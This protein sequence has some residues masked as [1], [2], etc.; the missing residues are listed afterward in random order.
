LIIMTPHIVK[1][2]EDAEEIRQ[3]EASRMNWCL[4]DVIEMHG[5]GGLRGR[6]DEWSDAETNVIYPDLDPSGQ[7]SPTPNDAPDQPNIVPAPDNPPLQ[8]PPGSPDSGA[9]MPG[10]PSIEAASVGRAVYPTPTYPGRIEPAIYQGAPPPALL[11]QRRPGPVV[12]STYDAPLRPLHSP[13]LRLPP[14]ENR[15]P[16]GPQPPPSQTPPSQT[17]WY[18]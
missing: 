7:A 1:N 15:P 16:V 18:R 6:N 5:D 13:V 11:H 12:R 2:E 10:G 14:T 4:G 8:L 3:V 17:S 9:T